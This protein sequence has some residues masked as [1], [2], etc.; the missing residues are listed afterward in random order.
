MELSDA[1][2]VFIYIFLV[3]FLLIYLS[4]DGLPGLPLDVIAREFCSNSDFTE[5]VL[6][7]YK[8]NRKQSVSYDERLFFFFFFARRNRRLTLLCL[9][10]VKQLLQ[11][12]DDQS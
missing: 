2:S 11:F 1:Y 9:D 12:L 5:K 4:N 6:C 3:E 8:I 10:F 7:K